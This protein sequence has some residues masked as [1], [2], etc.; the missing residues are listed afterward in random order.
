MALVARQPHFTGTCATVISKRA[1]AGNATGLAGIVNANCSDQAKASGHIPK[2]SIANMTWSPDLILLSILACVFIYSLLSTAI[3]KTILTLPILF[4]AMGYLLSE[5]LNH[6]ADPHVL[7]EGKRL[8]AEVT[9]VLVLFSDASHVRFRKLR[10]LVNLPVRMLAIGLPLTVALGTL[11]V[12]MI[13]PAGGLAMALLTAAVLTPTDAALGQTVVTS[14]DVPD[15]LRQTINVESGLNDGL[16][17]PF[18]LL[19]AILV[20]AGSGTA[21][22]GGLALA[23]VLQIVLGP[24]IGAAFGWVYARAMD[25]AQTRGY[26]A[27]AA[28]GVAFLSG[29]FAAFTAAEAVGGNGFIAV[30]VAGMVFGSSYRN[31]CLL[32]T[33]PS[34]RDS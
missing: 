30:F 15:H 31:D 24:L 9:L 14:P 16:A 26:M 12:F 10:Q 3:S 23:V 8:V 33:S 29:A 28:G 18:V 6:Y 5:P 7:D 25:F 27:Q 21:Q 19:G 11:V 34:P 20:S 22:T 17:L 13:L 32:Y 1:V 4:V 2:A